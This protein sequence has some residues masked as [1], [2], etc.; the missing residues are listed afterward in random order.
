MNL[1]LV[2]LATLT[3]ELIF[4]MMLTNYILS[5][6]VADKPLLLITRCRV[7]GH[8]GQLR[9]ANASVR[10]S[11]VRPITALLVGRE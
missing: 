5:V 9:L 6:K 8:V 2:D 7:A 1:F 4:G 11:T 10:P 3:V